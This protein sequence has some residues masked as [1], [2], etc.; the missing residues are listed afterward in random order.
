[1]EHEGLW[2]RLS[3]ENMV[4]IYFLTLKRNADMLAQFFSFFFSEFIDLYVFNFEYIYR[5]KIIDYLKVWFDILG[6]AISFL[7]C[8]EF[9]EKKITSCVCMLN[10]ILEP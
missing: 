1:M 2:W 8:S 6:N 7:S 5:G 4:S 3:L 9:N 10:K